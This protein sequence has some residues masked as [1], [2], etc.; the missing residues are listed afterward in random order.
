MQNRMACNF[1]LYQNVR[2][3]GIFFPLAQISSSEANHAFSRPT[4]ATPHKTPLKTNFQTISSKAAIYG[5]LHGISVTSDLLPFFN[6]SSYS[7]T[8]VT[9]NPFDRNSGSD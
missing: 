5:V 7:I 2:Q 8:C 6:G 3:N 9:M 1:I 4:P